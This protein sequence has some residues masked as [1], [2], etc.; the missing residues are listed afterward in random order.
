MGNFAT[1]REHLIISMYNTYFNS[2]SMSFNC[3]V[4]ES[5]VFSN[6]VHL[7]IFM[8][9]TNWFWQPFVGFVCA[10]LFNSL[11]KRKCCWRRLLLNER[12]CAMCKLIS[13]L[14][15][16]I[17]CDKIVKKEERWKKESSKH[18]SIVNANVIHDFNNGTTQSDCLLTALVFSKSVP[19]RRA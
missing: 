18:L 8:N 17:Q 12:L 10:Y 19:R 6:W 4:G 16:S 2:I 7:S 15:S 11:C 9:S 14:L 3:P 13:V 1:K 5:K